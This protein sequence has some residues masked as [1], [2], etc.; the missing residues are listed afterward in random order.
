MTY[1]FLASRQSCNGSLRQDFLRNALE[2]HDRCK[3]LSRLVYH[4][5]LFPSKCEV[6][7]MS[8]R[9]GGAKRRQLVT[10]PPECPVCRQ[11]REKYIAAAITRME[12]ENRGPSI[13]MIAATFPGNIN[14][15]IGQGPWIWS[16]GFLP[17]WPK[18]LKESSKIYYDA[19]GHFPGPVQW[20]QDL[21]VAKRG[22][23]R[24]FELR[25]TIYFPIDLFANIQ[26][27]VTETKRWAEMAKKELIKVSESQPPKRGIQ[28]ETNLGESFLMLVLRLWKQ[29]SISDIARRFYGSKEEGSRRLVIRRINSTKKLLL[30]HSQGLPTR[31]RLGR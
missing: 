2:S 30:A 25:T 4:R 29:E 27:Q 23:D 3:G 5:M 19:G 31:I 22:T 7:I 28:R 9:N 21:L 6:K 18:E 13:R 15:A 26:E 17:T 24:K 12:Y 8:K 1:P 10:A 11:R 20:Y 14:F 16:R